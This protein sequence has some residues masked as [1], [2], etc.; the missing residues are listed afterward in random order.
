V[1]AASRTIFAGR[2]A[3]HTFYTFL[4]DAE[5]V[6]PRPVRG[7]VTVGQVIGGLPDPIHNAPALNP[8]SFPVHPNHWCFVPKSQKFQN[9]LKEGEMWGRSFRTLSWNEPSWTV[10]YGHREMHVHPSGRRRVSI[11]EAM[12]LQSFPEN[13]RLLGTI[14]DQCALVS[15]AVPPKLARQIAQSIRVSLKI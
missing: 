11:Y 10:A 2:L 1:S 15:D 4:S 7:E 8:E 12:L 3:S 6:P 14:T 5:W 9:G 13:Y